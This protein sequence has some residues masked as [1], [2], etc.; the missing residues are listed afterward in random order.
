MKRKEI[1]SSSFNPRFVYRFISDWALVEDVDKILR[2]GT[3]SFTRR[4][5][6]SSRR[7]GRGLDNNYV[8]HDT[9]NTNNTITYETKC[10]TT[11]EAALTNRGSSKRRGRGHSEAGN[12]E[13]E[14]DNEED[15]RRKGKARRRIDFLKLSEMNSPIEA[16]KSKINC[17]T[18]F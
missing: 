1:N 7:R 11:T 15:K 2:V 4:M 17:R 13:P 18:Y 12:E 3:T 16:E 6:C 5:L 8:G 10:Y 9:T 14:D